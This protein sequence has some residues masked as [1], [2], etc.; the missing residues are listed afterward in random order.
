[1]GA[2]HEPAACAASTGAARGARSLVAPSLPA[3]LRLL[4]FVSAAGWGQSAGGQHV[5]SLRQSVGV[6]QSQ[7]PRASSLW[8]PRVHIYAL[9]KHLEEPCMGFACREL[10]RHLRN[11]PYYEPDPAK[12]DVFW[13]ARSRRARLAARAASHTPWPG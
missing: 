12:A 4:L 11:S 6:E 5:Q 8:R 1:M 7:V 2:P 13:C 10:T 3:L 9:P